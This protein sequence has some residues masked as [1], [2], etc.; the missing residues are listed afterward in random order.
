MKEILAAQMK[1]GDTPSK[2]TLC[3]AV[4]GKLPVKYGM[5]VFI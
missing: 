3:L 5:P 4:Y 2:P 1:V